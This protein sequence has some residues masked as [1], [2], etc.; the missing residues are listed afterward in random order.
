MTDSLNA[1]EE[2]G[3]EAAPEPPHPVV[4]RR[5]SVPPIIA[6]LRFVTVDMIRN[7]V[8]SLWLSGRYIFG[9]L[10][11]PNLNSPYVD[12]MDPKPRLEVRHLVVELVGL[13]R[14]LTRVCHRGQFSQS[15]IWSVLTWTAGEA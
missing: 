7:Y 4:R 13:S 12:V 6:S 3:V 14:E 5:A 10:F 2:S 8:I 15:A 9:F 11:C 1:V